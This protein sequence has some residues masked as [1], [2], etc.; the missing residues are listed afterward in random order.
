MI[1]LIIIVIAIIAGL[2]GSYAGAKNTKKAWR[3]FGIPTLIMLFAL[4]FI[5]SWWLI[6]IMFLAFSLSLGYGIPSIFPPDEGSLI[7]RFWY[8][9]TDNYKLSEILTRLTIGLG[10]ILTLIVIPILNGNWLQYFFSGFAF[11]IINV[12]FGGD[13][14]VKNEET[15]T[16]FEK[17]LLWEEF[18]IYGCLMF[19]TCLMI[20]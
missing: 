4:F 6:T 20:I 15:F 17:R 9:K 14:I 5:T 13:A 10:I 2:L 11:V 16:I 19:L 3:R 1:Y 12:I 18:I 8:K 7:G